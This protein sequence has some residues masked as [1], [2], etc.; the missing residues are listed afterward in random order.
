[1]KL[2][3]PKQKVLLL[4]LVKMNIFKKCLNI[5]YIIFV[6]DIV[7]FRLHGD[8]NFQ[9]FTL[10]NKDI[11]ASL[12]FCPNNVTTIVFNAIMVKQQKKEFSGYF[13]Y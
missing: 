10:K 13:A 8:S 12:L 6:I 4:Q 1:M 5:F 9:P 7:E 3:N 11:A 2:G